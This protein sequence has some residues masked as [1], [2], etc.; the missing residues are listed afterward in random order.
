MIDSI[1]YIIGNFTASWHII[2]LCFPSKMLL[3][4]CHNMPKNATLIFRPFVKIQ[5]CW[6]IGNWLVNFCKLQTKKVGLK[7]L[8]GAD[9][10]VVYKVEEL[11]TWSPN[12]LSVNA[13]NVMIGFDTGHQTH[14]V[15]ANLLNCFSVIFDMP[16]QALKAFYDSSIHLHFWPGSRTAANW[17]ESRGSAARLIMRKAADLIFS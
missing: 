13:I 8:Q 7:K 14:K 4:R 10:L 1:P 15:N 5:N 6:V 11:L 3:V 16:L 17:I 12:S 2:V 9:F